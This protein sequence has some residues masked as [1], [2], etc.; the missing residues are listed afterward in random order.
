M[1]STQQK[2]PVIA[3]R[4]H[5]LNLVRATGKRPHAPVALRNTTK[6]NFEVS[7]YEFL[8]RE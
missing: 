6:T 7:R 2:T 5:L 8:E 4:G 3:G 1:N